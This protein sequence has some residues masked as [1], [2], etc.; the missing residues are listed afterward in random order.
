MGIAVLFVSLGIGGLSFFLLR[1]NARLGAVLSAFL[2]VS[3]IPE[4]RRRFLILVSIEVLC[5]LA[6][7]L[8]FGLQN[9]GVQLSYDPDLPLAIAFLA[10]MLTLGALVW[11]GLTPRPLTE[12][13]REAAARDAPAVLQGLWLVPVQRS[14]ADSPPAGSTGEPGSTGTTDSRPP[15][16]GPKV[17]AAVAVAKAW[18]R[19]KP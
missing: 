2:Q 15:V 19:R 13:E 1:G 14:D 11:V 12:D 6:T 10:S 5:F 3:L 9:L 17:P 4:R 16:R 8:I 18:S 7:G